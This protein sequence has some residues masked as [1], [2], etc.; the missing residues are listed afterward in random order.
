MIFS[1]KFKKKRSLSFR[2]ACCFQL[3]GERSSKSFPAEGKTR[4]QELKLMLEWAFTGFPPKGPAGFAPLGM[5]S[6]M[7]TCLG[8][9]DHYINLLK[10]RVFLYLALLFCPLIHILF[11]FDIS[12]SQLQTSS[13]SSVSDQ[14]PP[15]KRKY[16]LKNKATV[17]LNTYSRGLV[18]F[19]QVFTPHSNKALN[20]F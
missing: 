6:T 2:N 3:A 4:E 14:Q 9:L 10:G 19:Y 1:L 5:K 17:P 18:C 13:D 20:K 12:E 11:W 7:S 16:V 8:Y 15:A